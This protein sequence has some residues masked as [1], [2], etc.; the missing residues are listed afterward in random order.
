MP[1][2]PF[3]TSD[4]DVILACGNDNLFRK[5][6]E[7]AGCT[8]LASDPRF[9]TNGKR[10]ENRAELTRLL[11]EIF[12]KRNTREWVGPAGGGGRAERADQ[13]YRAGVRRA[14]GA[15]RAACASS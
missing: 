8:E 6:C 1:Y 10:V 9:A 14:A 12:G 11:Q 5:F 2:Q 7:A 3:R 15:R 13:R 4:G